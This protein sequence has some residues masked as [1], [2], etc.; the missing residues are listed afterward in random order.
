MPIWIK[1]DVAPATGLDTPFTVRDTVLFRPLGG[2]EPLLFPGGF[3]MNAVRPIVADRNWGDFYSSWLAGPNVKREVAKSIARKFSLRDEDNETFNQL[4]PLARECLNY[5]E[6]QPLTIAR[7]VADAYTLAARAANG[8][9][10]EETT[11]RRS[12][13][14][15]DANL[16]VF[17]DHHMT[18][19]DTPHRNY[20]LEFNYELY[21][22]VLRHYADADGEFCLV[23][24]GDLEECVIYPPTLSDSRARKDAAPGKGIDGI[25]YPV[26]LGDPQWDAFLDLR[27]AQREANQEQVI[28]RF[29]DYYRLIR[30][31]FIADGRYVRLAGNHDPYLDQDRER[32]LRDRIQRE[33]GKHVGTDDPAARVHDLVRVE[34]GGRVSYVITHGHQFDPVCNQHGDIQYAKSLGETLSECLGWAYQGA[35]RMWTLADTKKWYIGNAY[36]NV[37]A[38]E[39]PGTYR[40]GGDGAWD[41]AASDI[42]LIKADSRDFVETLLGAEVAWEYFENRDAFHALTL[43]IWTGDE[44]YKMK[45]MDEVALCKGF[46]AAF[47]ALQPEGVAVPLPKLVL[48]H[49]HE[50]RQNAVFPSDPGEAEPWE[51]ADTGA[52]IVYLNSGS[53]GRYENLIWCV[54]IRGEDDRIC[55]WSRVDGKLKKITWRSDGDQLVHDEIEWI[56]V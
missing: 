48:G 46:A 44:L 24:N 10:L 39:E 45:H 27:Y 47:L 1:G 38:R 29:G 56:A 25:D 3:Y 43:E 28:A 20:F 35:D 18:A 52:G 50:P 12:V 51:Q 21:L 41:L 30:L 8:E 40:G 17:S 13:V 37:L 36:Q 14:R 11:F 2:G 54:E 22:D 9:E 16:V 23:E 53:A 31:R 49:T 5:K 55:S 33:L 7:T 19:Y 32:V 4:W 34:R 6:E 15:P 42:D 26:L